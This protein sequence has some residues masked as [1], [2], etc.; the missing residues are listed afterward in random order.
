[1]AG[2]TE[3]KE[4]PCAADGESAH[5]WLRPRALPL[6]SKRLTLRLLKA[7]AKGLGLPA[8]TTQEDLRQMIDGKLSDRGREPMKVQAWLFATEEET[9]VR[10]IKLS[11]AEGYFLEIPA[12]PN[13]QEPQEV[14]EKEEL[15]LS[16]S[17]RWVEQD[18]DVTTIQE[19]NPDSGLKQALYEAER[20]TNYLEATVRDL[21]AELRQEQE[22]KLAVQ[23]SLKG[24]QATSAALREEVRGLNDCVKHER[25]RVKNMWKLNCEQLTM[26]DEECGRCVNECDSKDREIELLRTRVREFECMPLTRRLNALTSRTLD[27]RTITTPGAPNPASIP[28][29]PISRL[30]LDTSIT[31]VPDGRVRFPA[32]PTIRAPDEY[33]VM[34]D[35]EISRTLTRNVDDRRR[36]GRAPPVDPFTGENEETRFEDWLPTLER[37]ATWNRWSSEEQLMQL[38][39][40]LR[41]KA[42]QEWNLIS[43]DDKSSYQ[44]ATS[45]LSRR[46]DPGGRVMAAQDFRHAIQKETETVADYLRRLER[47]FQLAYGRDDLK[48]ETRETM[49]YSQLQEGLL[50]NLVRSP[51]VSGCQRYK[52]LCIAAK[53]EEKRLADIKRRQVYA[54]KGNTS[55]SNPKK[56]FPDKGASPSLSHS[57]SYS[58]SD[59]FSDDRRRPMKPMKPRTLT[60][61]NCGSPDHFVRDCKAPSKESSSKSYSNGNRLKA[62]QTKPLGDR[63]DPMACLYTSSD[64]DSDSDVKLIRVPYEGS[65]PRRALVEVQGIPAYGVVDTGADISIMGAELFKTVAAATRMKKRSLKSVDKAAFTYDHKPIKLDGKLELDIVF[66]DKALATPVYLKMDSSDQ[67][68]LSEGVCCQLGIV[69]YHPSVENKKR[70][71]A[72]E[73][74]PV[75]VPVVRVKLVESLSVPPLRCVPA[76]VELEGEEGLQGPF[77]VEDLDLDSPQPIQLADSLFDTVGLN[78]VFRV[79]LENHTGFTQRIEKDTQVGLASE[80]HQVMEEES[81]PQK[82]PPK[83]DDDVVIRMITSDE[84]RRKYLASILVDEG[85]GL[86]WQ[87]KDKLYSLLMVNHSV[88]ALDKDERGETDLIQME[89]F[90][91]ET[92]P[93][94]QPVRRTPF[95]VRGEVARQLRE[96]Q[97]NGVISPSAS[98][99]ASP[100]VLVRKKDG[101]LRFCIDY[102]QLNSLTKADTFPLPRID[103]LLDQLNKAKYFST[104]DLASG[105]WKVQVHPDSKEKTAFITHQG[106]YQFNVMPFG[107]RNAPAVFQR[108]MQQVL[109]GL[110]PEEGVPFASVYIDDIL[111]FSQSFNDHLQHL[112]AVIDRVASAGLRLKPSKCKFIRQ[113]VEYLGH[114]LTPMGICPNPEKVRAVQ[115]FPRPTS[116][117]EVRQFLGLASYYRRFVKGFADI[118]QPL[119]ALTK[120]NCRYDWTADCQT[121]FDSLKSRM[122][123]SPVLAFPDFSLP[124]TLETDASIKGLGAVLSQRGQEDGKV[125][126]VA[127]ASRALS[128]QEQRYSVTEL[129]TLAVVWAVKHYHAYLY[130]HDVVVYTD[131]SAVKAVLSN[132]QANGKHARWWSQVYCS[133]IKNLEIV[134]RAGRDNANADALSRAPVTQPTSEVEL[135]T[136]VQI[137][138]IDSL[139]CEDLLQIDPDP[140]QT[141]IDCDLSNE[142]AEDSECQT[143]FDFLLLGKLPE[144][145]ALAKKVAAQ[146]TLFDVVD[147]VL[148]FLVPKGDGKARRVVPKSLRKTLIQGYHSSAMSGH[149]SAPKLV[150]AIARHWWWQ[151]MHGE[152]TERCG[153]CLQCTAVNASGRIHQPLLTPIPVQRAFQIMGLDIM[154][155]PKT[156]NG[157]RYV[158]VFQDFLTKWPFVFAMPDQKAIRLVRLLVEEVIPITGVPESLLS[159]RG[160]NLLSHLMTD[161]CALLGVKKLNTTSYHPACDG[162]VERFNRT[163]KT[164]LRKRAAE[165]GDQWDRYLSGVV[166]AYRNV[167]HE[168]TGEKPSFLLYGVDL[169]SPTEAALLPPSPLTLTDVDDYREELVYSLSSARRLAAESIKTAQQ[170]YKKYHDLHATPYQYKLGNWVFIRFPQEESGR[171]RKLS[172]PRGMVPIVLYLCKGQMCVWSKYISLRKEKFECTN[173]G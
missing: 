59:K 129:E 31:P 120:A 48:S 27:E 119:H 133:G 38:A 97:E 149:F 105:F 88:F 25:E 82:E 50:L 12:E 85:Q 56:R 171:M 69:S 148:C 8:D 20:R 104:L 74:P 57:H 35:T 139:E 21:E 65:H 23:S 155:L 89:I 75:R 1:M 152:I 102:R 26:L 10:M 166:W 151:G 70:G 29:V 72:K 137:A 131:H 127:Y 11:D 86:R 73:K 77:V 141:T 16:D 32:T 4:E 116:V 146:A 15:S 109:A 13:E 41:G 64:S 163:L 100:V 115:Q 58:H 154:E 45:E 28:T 24:E 173:R 93:K 36:S 62:I 153:S 19:T 167:P 6:N 107:L 142:Q 161:V 101:T 136:D 132:P 125:H 108:L 170:K 7:I 168:S 145:A 147:G 162:L 111:I 81:E 124:F 157:N 78:E 150:K 144:D 158:A 103:D 40:H 76:R 83:S 112:E 159:D 126:P 53:Q 49:L 44:S 160:T 84:E 52:E 54:L 165:C 60:C 68:L 106:L 51:S 96:M 18:S 42:L 9:N 17:E 135:V 140:N 138:T 164:A 47:Q 94:R 61:H 46:M 99:W 71:T 30:D 117:K 22:A 37:A 55:D 114:V 169:R 90:T 156:K 98:P 33:P 134:Y 5:A 63:N 122:L 14:K 130:G 34:V 91:N 95:A 143:M 110:N 113:T 66:E 92:T 121:S 87:D 123:M 172:R 128:P 3:V 67:L 2:Q 43:P 39:G 80:A 118:A 79:M